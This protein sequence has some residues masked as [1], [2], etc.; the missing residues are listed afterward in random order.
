MITFYM[1]IALLHILLLF[2]DLVRLD[3]PTFINH[4]TSKVVFVREFPQINMA[5]CL[6]RHILQDKFFL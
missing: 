4:K 2:S 5:E 1:D 6:F 3:I